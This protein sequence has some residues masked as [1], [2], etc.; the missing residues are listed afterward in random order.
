ML[1]YF[2]QQH[3]TDCNP[4]KGVQESQG[5]VVEWLWS[6]RL[7]RES[8]LH[9]TADEKLTKREL[10]HKAMLSIGQFSFLASPLVKNAGDCKQDSKY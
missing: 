5:V 4:N 10:S 9:R 8:E 2:T 1:V 6:V 3:Q 7:V